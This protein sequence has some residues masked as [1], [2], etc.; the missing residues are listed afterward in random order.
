MRASQGASSPAHNRCAGYPSVGTDSAQ[1]GKAWFH[2]A[3]VFDV[4]GF[5]TVHSQL[6]ARPRLPPRA[7]QAIT[8]NAGLTTRLNR[9]SN[10]QAP[11]SSARASD[12]ADPPCR[13]WRPLPTLTRTFALRLSPSIVRAATARRGRPLT[14]PGSVAPRGARSCW[15]RSGASRLGKPVKANPSPFAHAADPTW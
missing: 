8:K 1:V 14:S 7:P 5:H 13:W 3:Q 12:D 6:S 9:S 11:F 10:R 2:A 15:T 4:V